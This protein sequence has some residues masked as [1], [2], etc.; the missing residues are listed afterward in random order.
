MKPTTHCKKVESVEIPYKHLSGRWLSCDP[1]FKAMR[2]ARKL[3]F[4]APLDVLRVLQILFAGWSYRQAI[5]HSLV[6]FLWFIF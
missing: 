3:L 5:S 4:L 1:T 2:E 6:G